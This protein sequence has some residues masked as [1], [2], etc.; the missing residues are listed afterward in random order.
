M[1]VTQYLLLKDKFQAMNNEVNGSDFRVPS[2]DTS[3]LP[4]NIS[5]NN[6]FQFK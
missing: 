2:V 1:Q 3:Y 4:V 5:F 6:L